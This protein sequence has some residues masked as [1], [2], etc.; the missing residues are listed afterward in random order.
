MIDEAALEILPAP[1]F[2][3]LWEQVHHPHFATHILHLERA[4]YTHFQCTQCGDCCRSGWKIHLSKAYYDQW[5]EVFDNHPSGRFRAPFTPYVHGQTEERYA[6]M[7]RTTDQACI[8]LEPDQSCFIHGHY[9]EE[10]LSHVCRTYPRGHKSIQNF[11]STRVLLHSCEAVPPL[12]ADHRELLYGWLEHD[13]REQFN[14]QN[15]VLTDH[16]TPAH[17]FLWLGLCFDVLRS[18][19][20]TAVFQRWRYLL[21]QLQG[22]LPQDVSQSQAR[23]WRWLNNQLQAQMPLVFVNPP[24]P[25][26]VSRALDWMC[27]VIP[28]PACVAWLQSLEALPPLSSASCQ[29]LNQHLQNYLEDRLLA[30]CYGDLFWGAANFWEQNLMLL[31]SAVAVQT[32]ARYYAHHDNDALHI[33]HLERASIHWTKVVEQ[34]NH[35]LQDFRVQGISSATATTAME[36]LLAL[37]PLQ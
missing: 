5:F 11:F 26:Q 1:Y 7:R 12:L 32:L 16:L 9:G 20:P 36:T 28:H 34:R 13:T 19:Y 4:A 27:R 8:F 2:E 18:A 17:N 31:L 35:L 15:F 29:V 37:T 30:V 21:Q 10:A 33:H 24:A 6:E 22:I 23:H 14:A 3:T 25:E